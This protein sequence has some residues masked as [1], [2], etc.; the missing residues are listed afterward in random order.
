MA[1]AMPMALALVAG[2]ASGCG[3]ASRGATEPGQMDDA[4]WHEVRFEAAAL[5][6][7]RASGAPW[8]SSGGDRSMEILGGLIG[9][10]VGY[11]E[12]GATIGAAMTSEPSPEAPAP[13]VMLK[14]GGDEYRIAAIGQTLAPRWRQPM[15]IAAARYRAETQVVLQVLDALDGGVLGQREMTMAELLVP[16]SRTLTGVGEVASLD[17]TVQPMA[18]RRPATF[19]LVVDGRRSLEDLKNGKDQRWA[20]VPVW[21]GDRVTVRAVG[22]ICPSRPTPCFDANGAEPGRWS[23]YNYDGFGQ[24]RHASLVGVAPDQRVM[25]G[26][27][28]SF[29]VEQAGLLLLFV[30]D[31]DEDNNEGGF[32]VEV[33]VEPAL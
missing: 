26:A 17:V 10:A 12:V 16:G 30:N 19:E 13:M 5:P 31:T 9:L 23:S 32:E 7:R 18:P 25:I 8:H 14:I 21:N 2:M 33:T 1:A 11:P 4:G 15:A 29:V 20:P 6:A 3:G 24:A 22:E 27:G 28:T